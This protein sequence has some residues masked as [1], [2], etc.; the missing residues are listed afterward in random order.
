MILFCPKKLGDFI[1]S[2]EV[3]DFFCP[4]SLGDFFLS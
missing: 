4:E 1:S 3:V 2:R